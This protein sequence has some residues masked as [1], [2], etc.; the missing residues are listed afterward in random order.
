[1]ARIVYL[2]F[3]L[4]KITGGQKMILRHVETLRELGFDAIL[5][6]NPDAELPR[7]LEQNAA[8]EIASP[9]KPDD[10]LV[11][12]EDA[13]NAIAA[14]VGTPYRVV[15]FCQNQFNFAA[16]SAGSMARFPPVRAPAIIVPSEV[17]ARTVR[18]MYPNHQVELIRAFADERVFRPGPERV[19]TVAYA[20]RKR[21]LEAPAIAQMF[22]HMHPRHAALPWRQL[23]G[24]SEA[25]VAKVFGSAALFLSLSRLESVGM[26][27][28]EAMAG[29]CICAGF[30]GVGGRAYATSE[31]GFWVPEDDCEAAADAL[32]EAADLV[33]AGGARL[34]DMREA[35][36]QTAA[37]WS[38]AAF[39]PELEAVWMRLAPE[40]RRNAG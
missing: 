2:S 22:R 27:P 11:A 17:A 26:T 19:P 18:R 23:E 12:P 39:R 6:L 40:A 34:A 25:E 37:A 7:G 1:V 13:P 30:M 20:P 24:A 8:V 3:P 32:A 16:M 21:P 38:Y 5:R 10:I 9:L 28:L 36:R 4:G 33:Q 31:N 29:G 14:L 35:A 15:I